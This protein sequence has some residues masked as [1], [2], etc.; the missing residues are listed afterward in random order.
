ME[1]KIRAKLEELRSALQS[2]G[3]DLELDSIDGKTVKLKLKGACSGCPGAMMT[4]KNG[5]EAALR[6][7]IDDEL[8]VEQVT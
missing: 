8:T 1:E 6:E 4:L 3:G 2:H 7:S 5:V